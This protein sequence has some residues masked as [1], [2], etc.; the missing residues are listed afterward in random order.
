MA[1]RPSLDEIFGNK[2]KDTTSIPTSIITKERPS[3][4]EI[5]G[6]RT[7]QVTKED[8]LNM[9]EDKAIRMIGKLQG[10]DKSSMEPIS[11]KDSAI[12]KAGLIGKYGMKG[13]T[14]DLMPDKVGAKIMD[15]SEK[16][17]ENFQPLSNIEK[18][19]ATGSELAGNVASGEVAGKVA[20]YIGGKVVKGVKSGVKSIRDYMANAPK[21]ATIKAEKVTSEIVKPTPSET[22]LYK[23]KG[24]TNPAIREAT[25]I[26]DESKTY[27]ELISKT[28]NK[29]NENMTKR[30][31]IIENNNFKVKGNDYLQEVYDL[32]NKLKS[33]GQITET[34]LGQIDDAIREE[35]QWLKDN[36]NPTRMIAQKRKEYLEDLTRSLLESN[37][38]TITQPARQQA[39]DAIRRGLRRVVN[40]NNPILTA[41]NDTYGGLRQAQY[42]LAKQGASLSNKPT[43]LLRQKIADLI[44]HPID[45]TT[46]IL[47]KPE[48]VLPAKTKYIK[49]MS[50][51][52][53]QRVEVPTPLVTEPPKVLSLPAPKGNIGESF[54]GSGKIPKLPNTI[55][56]DLIEMSNVKINAP[57]IY[58][59]MG[60]DKEYRR[61]Q[62]LLEEIKG[63]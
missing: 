63:K 28:G 15:M 43:K 25:K 6:N 18:G 47:I 8:L 34:E 13:L 38:S 11:L 48:S 4:D 54:I 50:T 36:P 42:Y 3:L 44:K 26:I 7:R 14:F 57:E 35:L 31:K 58:K 40:N 24:E 30:N 21:R 10:M 56:E 61:L 49:K 5:F 19:I 12:N 23:A 16:D 20:G 59:Q 22:A 32:K 27:D 39:L 33:G 60:G 37:E 53:G 29:V 2:S 55:E 17:Y 51:K 45:T 9:P 1:N 41:L 62:M 52:A 46:D